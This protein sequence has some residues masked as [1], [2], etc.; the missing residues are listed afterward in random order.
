MTGEP[1]ARHKTALTRVALSRP[2]ATAL[3][4]GLLPAGCDRSST[5]AAARVTTSAIFGRSA[6]SSMVGTLRT[7]RTRSGAL[8]DS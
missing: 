7:G 8:S 4:D 1:V 3:A 5:T 2:M 6:M